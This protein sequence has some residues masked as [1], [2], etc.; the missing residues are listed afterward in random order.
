[1]KRLKITYW[2]STIFFAT[3]FT[4]T[5][6]LYLLHFPAIA[7]RTLDLYY[8]AYL[9]DI[10]GTA[11]ILGAVALV[12]PKYKHLK[13]WAYAGFTFDFIGAMW[14]H[15]YVQGINKYVLIIIPLSILMVSYITYHRLQ[16]GQARLL[17]NETN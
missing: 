4:T 9:L 7:K 2:V 12:T 10:I 6:I 13:E 11:K 5:G 1:M 15:F 17:L 16:A 3:I 14:S 8:P